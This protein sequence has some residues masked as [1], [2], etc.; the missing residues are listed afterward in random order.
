MQA[1][2]PMPPKGCGAETAVSLQGVRVL[3]LLTGSDLLGHERAN[4]EVFRQLRELGLEPLFIIEEQYGREKI[5]PALEAHGFGW[6]A[7]PFG[8]H[9]GRYMLGRYFYYGFINLW[10]VLATSW[11]LWRVARRFRPHCVYS[12]NW[13]ALTYA[14]P[15]L[16]WSDLPLIYRAGDAVPDRTAFHRWVNRLI[17]RRGTQLV[18]NGEFLRSRLAEALPW[19]K[20]KVIRNYP[21]ARADRQATMLPEVPEGTVVVGYAGQIGEHKGVRI[22]IEAIGRLLDE[23]ANVMLWLAGDSRWEPSFVEQLRERVQLAGWQDRIRFL[24]FIEN[25]PE[26][27]ALCHVHVCP[28]IWQDPSPNVIFEA[29]QAGKPSVVFPMGG[30]SELVEHEV[31]G[32]VCRDVTVE[33]LIEGIR[34]FLQNSE[35]AKAAGAAA[36]HS[37]VEKFGLP[38]FRKQWAEVFTGTVPATQ[39]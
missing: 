28:S 37:L 24:G 30:L 11:H 36:R 27:L 39:H 19:L 15:F 4:I 22:L 21:P 31:D 8:Y 32:F 20:A 16:L 5:A 12:G 17:F 14:L 29:K 33:A 6:V 10:R 38:D 9:W 25:V 2:E 3:V 13:T 35:R 26:M 1:V 23:G 18:C 34:F 7:A